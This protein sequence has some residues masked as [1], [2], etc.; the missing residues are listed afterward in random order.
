MKSTKMTI[1]EDD[2]PLY[3]YLTKR[4]NLQT[5]PSCIKLLLPDDDISDDEDLVPIGVLQ[6]F[7]QQQKKQL[8]S[9]AQKYKERVLNYI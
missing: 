3:Q 5:R 2:I 8:Q 6:T 1:E 7:N 9:A 4:S